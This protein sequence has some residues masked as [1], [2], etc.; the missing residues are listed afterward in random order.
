[1]PKLLIIILVFSIRGCSAPGLLL[2]A[3]MLVEFCSQKQANHLS[4]L[5][6]VADYK[7]GG[8]FIAS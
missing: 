6:H 5:A 8:E 4:A 3:V 7:M 1:M 2:A